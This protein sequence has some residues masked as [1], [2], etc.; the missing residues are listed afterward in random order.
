MK[1][2]I[3]AIYIRYK[4]DYYKLWMQKNFYAFREDLEKHLGKKLYY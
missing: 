3:K 4:S 1:P 2:L